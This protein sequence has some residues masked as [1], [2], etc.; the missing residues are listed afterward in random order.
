MDLT[1]PS[2]YSCREST[3]KITY[4]LIP[5]L[6]KAFCNECELHLAH[7][8]SS[9][10]NNS[11]RLWLELLLDLTATGFFPLFENVASY[12]GTSMRIVM[13]SLRR[14]RRWV[15]KSLFLPTLKILFL[16]TKHLT[17]GCSANGSI[18]AINVLHVC[19]SLITKG[20]DC[21]YFSR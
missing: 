13:S 9:Y 6:P 1:T 10:V 4:G 18:P 20:M 12:G 5:M 17:H 2:R 3:V 16:T 19:L 7:G 21:A 15:L 8:R 11:N 14:D